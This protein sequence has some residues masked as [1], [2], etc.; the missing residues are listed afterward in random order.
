M[1]IKTL[2]M[3]RKWTNQTILQKSNEAYRPVT[4]FAIPLTVNFSKM[5]Y[6]YQNVKGKLDRNKKLGG[7]TCSSVH[8]QN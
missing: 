1:H 8:S 6:I 3:I 2:D 5:T 4:M 7:K